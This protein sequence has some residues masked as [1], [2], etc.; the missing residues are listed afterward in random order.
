MPRLGWNAVRGAAGATAW[1]LASECVE[2]TLAAG[3]TPSLERLG[4]LGR[5]G[6][7]PALAAAVRTGVE[8]ARVALEYT[9][10]RES[11]GFGP[12]EITSELLAL[13]RV[14]ERRGERAARARLDGCIVEHVA[15]VTA[16]LAERA[17]RDPL[18]GLLNHR[19][20]HN[21]VAAEIA[22]ARRYRSRIALVVFDL[23]CFKET[24]DSDGHQE[25]DRLL[26]VFA[27]ALS[28]AA[29]GS[30][31]V[32]RLGGDEFAALLIEAKRRSAAV[33]VD[34]VQVR[35]RGRVAFSAGVALFPD[36]SSAADQLLTLADSRLYEEKAKKAA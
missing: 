26:R 18:T 13:G 33:F 7:L 22:R 23:D 20:F 32:G 25:G 27:S 17:R 36:E 6:A 11:L 24:N 1:D 28:R 2:E 12:A 3:A 29:R 5:L 34:R 30:D 15:R 35:L 16:Q 14:L 19:A 10:E 8:P 31:A 9:R 4:R 21:R